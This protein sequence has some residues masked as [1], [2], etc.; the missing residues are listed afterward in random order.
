MGFLQNA[1]GEGSSTK[2]FNWFV[3]VII[4]GIWGA[5]CWEKKELLP[6]D[7]TQLGIIGIG[8]AV[9]SVNKKFELDIDKN[10]V[11]SEIRKRIIKK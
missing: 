1:K 10:K 6:F 8:Q 4:L 5:L 2:V 11:I 7:M 9:N 3:A